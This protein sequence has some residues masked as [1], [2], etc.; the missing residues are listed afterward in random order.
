MKGER[1]LL[2]ELI[3]KIIIKKINEVVRLEYEAKIYFQL[4]LHWSM[5]TVP[6]IPKKP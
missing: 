1:Q 5:D 6:M 2:K 4:S 3:R